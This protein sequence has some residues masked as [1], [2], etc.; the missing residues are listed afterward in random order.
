MVA[1]TAPSA[2]HAA[3]A[4]SAILFDVGGV[5]LKL[6]PEDSFA[7][8]AEAGAP[9]FGHIWQ[10]DTPE[11]SL[12]RFEVGAIDTPQFR[13]EILRCLQAS[14]SDDVFDAAFGA[15]LGPIDDATWRLLATL[16]QQ[17]P[18]YVLS[19]NNVLHLRA[20]E[21]RYPAFRSY[22]V[23]AYFSQEIAA[24]KPDAE[25]FEKTIAL[26]SLPAARTLFIDDSTANITAAQAAGLQ[27]LYLP[28][29]N[30]LSAALQSCL[31]SPLRV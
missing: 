6:R 14:C 9:G 26:G 19:N 17:L 10:H 23:G 27:T 1:P 13:R 30:D 20:I 15:M 31:P 24:R 2:A 16:K 28:R 11:K 3:E 18:L 22:F 21:S 5:L 7:A 12:Y 8:F 29:N 4:P 25:A